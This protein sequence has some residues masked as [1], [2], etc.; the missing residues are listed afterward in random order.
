L[1]L[2]GYGDK[3]GWKTILR[4][5]NVGTRSV[6]ITDVRFVF[7]DKDGH[8]K[9]IVGNDWKIPRKLD[10]G[11]HENYEIPSSNFEVSFARVESSAGDVYKV[12]GPVTN[13]HVIVDISGSGEEPVNL[14][15]SK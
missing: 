6:T 4:V 1:K 15:L 5:V 12:D 13:H 11:D 9:H 3:Y 8:E 10:D 7:V 2:F 14:P